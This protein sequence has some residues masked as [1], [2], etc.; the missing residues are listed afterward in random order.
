M[1]LFHRNPPTFTSVGLCFGSTGIVCLITT[2]KLLL[3]TLCAG[4]MGP[5][6]QFVCLTVAVRWVRSVELNWL[7]GY[8]VWALPCPKRL[9]VLLSIT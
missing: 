3:S 6:V 9:P 4:V 5:C 1:A 7:S 8:G 2:L